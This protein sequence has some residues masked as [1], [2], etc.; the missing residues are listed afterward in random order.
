VFPGFVE[1]LMISIVKQSTT[2]IVLNNVID[3]FQIQLKA[4]VGHLVPVQ[5]NSVCS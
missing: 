1:L 2:H 5:V 3:M 4:I